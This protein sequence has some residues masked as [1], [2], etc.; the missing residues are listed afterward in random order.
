[1]A[2]L[3]AGR[4][5]FFVIVPLSCVLVLVAG[6]L[7]L[8]RILSTSADLSFEGAIN[9]RLTQGSDSRGIIRTC[10]LG[11]GQW[12]WSFEGLLNGRRVEASIVVTPYHGPGTYTYEGILDSQTLEQLRQ[13][14]F[15]QGN[16]PVY[17]VVAMGPLDALGVTQYRSYPGAAYRAIPLSELTKFAPLG[18]L[19]VVLNPDEKSGRVT[20]LLMSTAGPT[21][22]PLHVSGSFGCG[23]LHRG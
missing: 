1:M 22:A 11:K 15:Y 18:R 20:G 21:A 10:F 17:M 5:K 9:G 16:V 3:F 4:R 14:Q 12:N 6:G 19:S 7:L 8:I 13:S 2:R 23:L